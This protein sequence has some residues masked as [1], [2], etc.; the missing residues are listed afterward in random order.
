MLL[1]RFFWFVSCAAALAV[2]GDP[3]GAQ[4]PTPRER[5]ES[6]ILAAPEAATEAERA[7]LY[8]QAL[9][10][11]Y[12]EGARAVL[13]ADRPR[14]QHAVEQ[15]GFALVFGYRHAHQA[16]P[17]ALVPISQPVSYLVYVAGQWDGQGGRLANASELA[18]DLLEAAARL[19]SYGLEWL[20]RQGGNSGEEDPMPGWWR[21]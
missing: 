8:F 9:A 19:R 14:L 6:L 18:N 16:Y 21:S 12:E 3:L 17:S 5:A 11:W 15:E 2:L 1:S 4:Y 7:R 13:T 10:E 20:C